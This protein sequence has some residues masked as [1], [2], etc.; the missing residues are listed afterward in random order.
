[1]NQ[2]V[3]LQLGQNFRLAVVSLG[4]G[5]SPLTANSANSPDDPPVPQ[6]DVGAPTLP[7]PAILPKG[8]KHQRLVA[9]PVAPVFTESRPQ[10]PITQVKSLAQ[11]RSHL[12]KRGVK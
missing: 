8:H 11:K 4:L 6:A 5:L 9:G 12:D 3:R 10:G 1:M 7:L 2:K